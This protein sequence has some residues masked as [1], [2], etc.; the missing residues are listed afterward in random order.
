[1]STNS[2]LLEE[3]L[4]TLKRNLQHVPRQ[5]LKTRYRQGYQTLSKK[6]SAAAQDYVKAV[7]L[8]GIRIRNEYANEAV[9]I[10]EKAIEESGLLEKISHAA[11]QRQ[12]LTEI[13]NL[14]LELNNRILQAL[15]PFFL[16]HSCPLF[17]PE[18]LEDP[19]VPPLSYS[20]VNDSFYQ[21]GT[22]VPTSGYPAKENVTEQ[23]II[24]TQKEKN[25][26]EPE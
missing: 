9:P 14:S 22:G 21:D 20:W 12:D 5:E 16:Q 1:M 8:S 15:H 7:A 23:R 18:F 24:H 6:I 3:H 19:S 17:T 10:I 4:Q 13:T 11:F 2:E 25:H 26:D